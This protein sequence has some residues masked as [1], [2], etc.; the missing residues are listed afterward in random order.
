MIG[1]VA[2]RT[3]DIQRY[4]TTSY[5][6]LNF[7]KNVMVSNKRL[8]FLN[9]DKMIFKVI[10]SSIPYGL[11]SLVAEIGGYVG[12]FLGISINQFGALPYNTAQRFTDDK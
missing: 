12:L 8:S 10:R 4:G 9:C 2:S 3:A 1:S 5:L 6:A 11:L 7:K